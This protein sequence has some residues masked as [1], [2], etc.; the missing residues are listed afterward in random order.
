M[1]TT[2][3]TSYTGSETLGHQLEVLVIDPVNPFDVPP[4]PHRWIVSEGG[5]WPDLLVVLMHL[6]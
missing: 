6:T 3:D 2:G 5:A 4:L 1:H